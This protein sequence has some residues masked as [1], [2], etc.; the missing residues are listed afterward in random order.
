VS[1]GRITCLDGERGKRVWADLV[2]SRSC[3]RV[4]VLFAGFTFSFAC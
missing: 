1:R 3:I 2:P 4:D